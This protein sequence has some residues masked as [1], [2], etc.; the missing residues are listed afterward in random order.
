MAEE[1][2]PVVERIAIRLLDAAQSIKKA[3]GYSFD[4]VASR[5]VSVPSSP[6]DGSIQLFQLDSQIDDDPAIPRAT[7]IG[8]RQPFVF[9][10]YARMSQ[11]D[12]TPIE[13]KL[14]MMRSDVERAVMSNPRLGGLLSKDVVPQ[15]PLT[16]GDQAGDGIICLYVW[17]IVP[18]LV[19]KTD[20]RRSF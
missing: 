3:D 10:C 17:F 19:K 2:L 8:W 14:N 11:Q 20:P 7:H 6:A 16:D 12:P 13:S 18:Y 1:E 4:A 15:P 5:V 9:A